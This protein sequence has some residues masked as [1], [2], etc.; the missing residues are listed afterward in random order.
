MFL[1][2]LTHIHGKSYFGKNFS[3]KDQHKM[4]VLL[5]VCTYAQYSVLWF[6]SP[7]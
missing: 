6:V 5:C 2:E 1:F 3:A 4:T 7:N